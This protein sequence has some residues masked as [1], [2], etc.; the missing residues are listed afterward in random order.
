[1]RIQLINGLPSLSRSDLWAMCPSFKGY[2]SVLFHKSCV[3]SQT[4]NTNLGT[5]V[6]NNLFLHEIFE[7]CLQNSV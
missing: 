1:M 6:K 3:F 2:I 7:L 4:M 5:Q